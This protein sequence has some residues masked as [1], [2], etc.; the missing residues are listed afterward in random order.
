[1][2]LA[3][4]WIKC[5]FAF[6]CT[7][8]TEWA[9][10]TRRKTKRKRKKMHLKNVNNTWIVKMASQV[11][12]KKEIATERREIQKSDTK[13]HESC[14]ITVL[15]RKCIRVHFP[16]FF[17][18]FFFLLLVLLLFA[19]IP[20]PVSWQTS[21]M[22]VIYRWIRIVQKATFRLSPDVKW[23]WARKKGRKWKVLHLCYFIAVTAAAAHTVYR[24][25]SLII[26][27][28]NFIEQTQSE[29]FYLCSLFIP[30]GYFV[31]NGFYQNSPWFKH[32][33]KERTKTIE[34][35]NESVWK[36]RR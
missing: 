22:V 2:L 20:C 8:W 32:S 27:Q 1:M 9:R 17:F 31:A 11:E 14:I 3:W 10:W 25:V 36:S 35:P 18:S 15:T 34:R 28:F 19:T 23:K 21:K 6:V 26:F 13:L 29:R 16:F 7:A 30:Y 5:I 12:P 4:Y 24:L 33:P